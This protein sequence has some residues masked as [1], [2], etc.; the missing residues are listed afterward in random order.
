MYSFDKKKNFLQST[1]RLSPPLKYAPDLSYP[2][3]LTY[4]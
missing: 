1:T 2:P 4:Q 3:M